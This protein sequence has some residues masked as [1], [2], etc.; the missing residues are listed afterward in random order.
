MDPCNPNFD[1][2][3]TLTPPSAVENP[4][5]FAEF[6]YARLNA[7]WDFKHPN[8]GFHAWDN[9]PAERKRA[10]AR[11]KFAVAIQTELE[12]IQQRDGTDAQPA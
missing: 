5:G 12:R 6:V 1:F 4:H 8:F 3:D 9:T 7:G 2:V 10:A 11:N